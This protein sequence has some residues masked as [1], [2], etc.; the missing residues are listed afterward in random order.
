MSARWERNA[1]GV[2][3]K[4]SVVVR[5]SDQAILIGAGHTQ[6]RAAGAV[7][8]QQEV[9]VNGKI[10]S[11]AKISLEAFEYTFPAT[12]GAA[13]VTQISGRKTESPV[14]SF[15]PMQPGGSKIQVKCSWD[16]RR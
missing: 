6:L 1:P 16:F 11:Q 10:T 7:Q 14:G 13:N 5:A 15:G 3:T 4:I 8:G 2:A 12:Q 9:R